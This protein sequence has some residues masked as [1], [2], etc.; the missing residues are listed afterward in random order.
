LVYR[1]RKVFIYMDYS[2][3]LLL[4]FA[5][6]LSESP[7]RLDEKE[8]IINEFKGD[9]AMNRRLLA[10]GKKVKLNPWFKNQELVFHETQ[11]VICNIMGGSVR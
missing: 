8:N 3:N 9:T 4:R 1:S 5:K 2:S 6:N 10:L 7:K 11:P